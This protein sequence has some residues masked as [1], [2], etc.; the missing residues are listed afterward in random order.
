[1][2]V[3]DSADEVRERLASGDLAETATFDAKEGAPK[4]PDLAVDVCAMTVNGGVLLF[5][6][7]ENV[8]GTR[9]TEERPIELVGQRE[10][11]DQMILT[12]INEPPTV[13]ITA[14]PLTEDA[15]RG[16]LVVTVPPSARSPHQVVVKGKYFGRFYTR[17][18]TG[19]RVL[20]QSEVEALFARRSRWE[21]DFEHEIRSV[22]AAHVPVA[23]NDR[24]ALTVVCNPFA[25]SGTMLGSTPA[26]DPAVQLRSAV[27]QA[28]RSTPGRADVGGFDGL[29]N[30]RLAHANAWQAAWPAD[31]EP[32]LVAEAARNGRLAVTSLRVGRPH[33]HDSATLMLSTYY[34]SRITARAVALGGQITAHAG[35]RGPVDV[36]VLVRPMRGV[37]TSRGGRYGDSALSPPYAA[38]D[39][40]GTG[41]VSADLLHEEPV[42]VARSVLDP[43]LE[44]T[45]GRGVDVFAD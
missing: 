13:T 36:G 6:A 23:R 8:D 12:G 17:D 34:L 26:G 24:V 30:W 42:A 9:V 2:W 11:A 7:G 14:L 5:G 41:R 1:M 25:A 21:R 22:H 39:Y 32:L 37:R 43:L 15:S 44:A 45:V 33:E 19:N 40:A 16:F 38:D 4:S 35:Y 27:L 10:R 31:G 18:D 20:G 28:V 3:P 29:L